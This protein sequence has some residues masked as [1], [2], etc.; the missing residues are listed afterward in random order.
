MI[1]ALS[2]GLALAACALPGVAVAAQPFPQQQIRLIVTTAPGTGS[3]T[4]A[5]MLE[6][7]MSE[8]LGQSVYVDNRPGA[9]GVLGMDL[10]AHA[11]PDGYTLVLGANGTMIASPAMNPQVVKYRMKDFVPVAGLLRSPFVMV[12]AN[13]PQA[14]KTAAELIA[15]SKEKSLSYGSSGIGTITHLASEM[16]LYRTGAKAVHVPYRG[17]NQSL[18]DLMAGQ[19]DFVSDTL[20]AVLPLI[21]SGKLRPIAVTS[22]SRVDVLPEVP[23]LVESGFPGL[24]ATGWWGLLAPAGTPPEAVKALSAAALKALQTADAQTRIKGLEMET[25]AM[26]PEAFAQFIRTE[27]PAW[28]EFI[29]KANIRAE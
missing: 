17:S 5:R 9:G 1:R 7:G 26:P 19:V 23:T 18:T 10:A 4:I 12:V 28:T 11:P 14:P 22:A 15:R 27:E 20:P 24:V 8:A 16:F 2:L 13:T 6:P 29:R 3:D 25:M 21:R